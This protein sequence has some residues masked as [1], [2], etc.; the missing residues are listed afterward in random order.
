MLNEARYAVKGDTFMLTNA[1]NLL[2]KRFG[3]L[4]ITFDSTFTVQ[5]GDLTR[6]FK[7]LPS[8]GLRL[9]DLYDS[10]GHYLQDTSLQ[11]RYE[12]DFLQRFLARS[13]AH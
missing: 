6:V 4:G 9:S 13:V 10:S 7:K 11:L 8:D 3:L 5:F 2:P 1:L 12:E